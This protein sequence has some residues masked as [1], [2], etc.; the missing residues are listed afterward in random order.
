M[1]DP[2]K[3]FFLEVA[4]GPDS[5]LTGEVSQRHGLRAERCS[6]F[7]G[8]DL[9]THKGIRAVL[10]VIDE[11]L[12][13]NVWIATE[14]SAFSPIQNLNQRNAEQEQRLRE[15]EAGSCPAYGMHLGCHVCP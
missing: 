7:N 2:E 15:A 4:C 5:L 1:R 13:E 6:H 8:L 11:E 10:P 3:L 9:I 14:C 12:P